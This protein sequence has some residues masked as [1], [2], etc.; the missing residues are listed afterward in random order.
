[1]FGFEAHELL[2]D[3]MLTIVFEL[4]ILS[5]FPFLFDTFLCL[6]FWLDHYYVHANTML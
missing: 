2:Q 3:L 4:R 6:R 1:M 5:L